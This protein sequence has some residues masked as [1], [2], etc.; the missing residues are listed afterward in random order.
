[1]QCDTVILKRTK[2]KQDRMSVNIVLMNPSCR[3]GRVFFFILKGSYS[4]FVFLIV[5]VSRTLCH[6]STYRVPGQS[7]LH[8]E[9]LTLR[10]DSS[11]L[12][13]LAL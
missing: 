12:K 8:S 7:R 9:T 11:I 13:S 3:Y 10:K 6:R 4:L 5:Q 1:M 2:N